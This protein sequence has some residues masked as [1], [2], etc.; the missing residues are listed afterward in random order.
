MPAEQRRAMFK[1][2]IATFV[3]ALNA[4]CPELAHDEVEART[5]VFAR[6]IGERMNEILSSADGTE[7]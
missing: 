7:R 1:L 6:S 5:M 2:C 3:D 4:Q